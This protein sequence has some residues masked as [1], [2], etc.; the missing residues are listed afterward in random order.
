VPITVIITIQLRTL[1]VSLEV[2]I[3]I[4]K[5]KSGRAIILVSCIVLVEASGDPKRTRI[6][7]ANDEYQYGSDDGKLTGNRRHL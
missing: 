1:C 3:E 5:L 4:S 2:R 7:E 6:A